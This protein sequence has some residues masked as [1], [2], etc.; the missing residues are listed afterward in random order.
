MDRREFLAAA[1]YGG[2]A[3]ALGGGLYGRM[4]YRRGRL[5]GTLLRDARPVLVEKAHGE[6]QGLPAEAHHDIR[7]WLHTRFRTR[8]M[9]TL[10]TWRMTATSGACATPQQGADTGEAM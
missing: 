3:V 8:A 7:M 2:G 10:N 9:A 4:R 1:G 5:A 6:M